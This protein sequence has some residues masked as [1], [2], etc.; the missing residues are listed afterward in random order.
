MPARSSCPSTRRSLVFP[1]L[2]PHARYLRIANHKPELSQLRQSAKTGYGRA[3]CPAISAYQSAWAVRRVKVDETDTSAQ[4]YR[5]TD[6]RADR[7]HSA[8]MSVPGKQVQNGTYEFDYMRVPDTRTRWQIFR[9]GIYNSENGTYCGHPPKKWG[10]SASIIVSFHYSL[11]SNAHSETVEEWI[12]TIDMEKELESSASLFV[13]TI[14][15]KWYISTLC[16]TGVNIRISWKNCDA[17]MSER[18]LVQRQFF[19]SHSSSLVFRKKSVLWKA[20]NLHILFLYCLKIE[21]ILGLKL[22][23]ISILR[24]GARNKYLKHR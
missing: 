8:V 21:N 19:S 22:V 17:W 16:Y 14:F 2:R 7:Q 12:G 9:D 11:D 10:E 24:I 23:K 20:E 1:L 3:A 5:S 15:E 18:F 4:T 13:G 6:Q